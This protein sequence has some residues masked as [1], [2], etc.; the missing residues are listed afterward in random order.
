[1]AKKDRPISDALQ[2]GYMLRLASGAELPVLGACPLRD[3]ERLIPLY[4][5]FAGVRAFAYYFVEGHEEERD[6]FLEFMYIMCGEKIEKDKFFDILTTADF[7]EVRN[8]ILR[9]LGLQFRSTG[10]DTE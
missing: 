8:A 6:A 7:E 5:Q 2:L 1:M 4:N 9:F 3:L 10:T